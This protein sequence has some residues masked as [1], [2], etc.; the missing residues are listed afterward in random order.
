MS[1]SLPIRAQTLCQT[2]NQ[3]LEA[4]DQALKEADQVI[5]KQG[6]LL[7]ALVN[8][9]SSLKDENDELSRAIIR[10]DEEVGDSWK[11]QA[12]IG[13]IGVGVG[14]TLGVLVSK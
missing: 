1:A 2:N 5:I 10:L 4:C 7:Q 9:N 6:E 11:N 8:Q 13:L 12:I 14:V 3:K